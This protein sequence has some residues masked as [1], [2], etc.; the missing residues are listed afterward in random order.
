MREEIGEKNSKLFLAVNPQDPTYE[1][2]KYSLKNKKDEDL[3][4]VNSMSGHKEK[5]G[6]KRT[7]NIEDKIE[8]VLKSRTTNMLIDFDVEISASIKSFAIKKRHDQVRITTRFLSGKLLMFAKLSVISFIYEL[9]ETFYF[10][11][12][13]V[14][15]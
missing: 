8:N 12:E 6:R 9:V 11:N 1:I 4:A 14:N 7:Y 13:T 10:P 15:I 5:I 2:R 3:D